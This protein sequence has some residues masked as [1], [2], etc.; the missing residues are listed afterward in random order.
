MKISGVKTYSWP[1]INTNPSLSVAI[2]FG[3]GGAVNCLFLFLSWDLTTAWIGAGIAGAIGGAFLAHSRNSRRSA[4]LA[5]VRYF[6][7]FLIGG[8][9]SGTVL[10]VLLE[11]GHD[12]TFSFFEFYF[13]FVLG[14]SIAGAVSAAFTR[15]Q[16][17][18]VGNSTICFL[19]GSAVGGVAVGVLFNSP[20]G[21]PYIAAIGLLVTYVVGGALSGAVSEYSDGVDE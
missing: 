20:M 14:F 4:M 3:L 17:I 2:G 11:M 7:G 13:C 15:S 12:T 18:S 8:V 21:K 1:T 5:A 10:V 19:V 9:I 6:L 16:P